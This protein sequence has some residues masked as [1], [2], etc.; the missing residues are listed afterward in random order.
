MILTQGYLR[1]VAADLASQRSG[2]GLSELQKALLGSFDQGG[3]GATSWPVNHGMRMWQDKALKE[4]VVFL[5][6]F[7]QTNTRF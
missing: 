2:L 1:P 4:V 3:G 6:L 5:V 7:L